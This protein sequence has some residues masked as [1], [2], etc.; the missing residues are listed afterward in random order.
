[1]VLEQRRESL[2][3]VLSYGV[4]MFADLTPTSR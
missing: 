2:R 1:M 3:G 4:H